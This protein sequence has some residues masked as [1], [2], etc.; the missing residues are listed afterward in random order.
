MTDRTAP[1]LGSS[2]PYTRR[3]IRACTNAPGAHRAR[4]NCN[5]EL[6]VFQT[7]VTNGRTGFAQRD[8]LGV[9]GRIGVGDVAIPSAAYDLAVADHDRADRDFS[10]F[11]CALGAAQGF[12]HPEFVGCRVVGRR[13]WDVSLEPTTGDDFSC[14][15]DFE[16][17]LNILAGSIRKDCRAGNRAGTG[18]RIKLTAASSDDLEY[19]SHHFRH[20]RVQ[21]GRDHDPNHRVGN[22]RPQARRQSAISSSADL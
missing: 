13:S 20:D 6:A 17:P 18:Y 1:A 11:E 4:F 14:G 7:M 12:L 15:Q 9:G 10:S 3:W 21:N 19:A 8:D 22:Y 5:K 2:A 16:A